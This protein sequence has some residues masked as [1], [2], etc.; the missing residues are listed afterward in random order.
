M[1][2]EAVAAQWHQCDLGRAVAPAEG[3][4]QPAGEG[5][6]AGVRDSQSREPVCDFVGA[7]T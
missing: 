6:T 7:L 1:Q 4:T 3:G 2:G 5:V